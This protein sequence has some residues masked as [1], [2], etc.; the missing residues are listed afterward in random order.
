MPLRASRI[1]YMYLKLKSSHQFKSSNP[2]SDLDIHHVLKNN[3][4][5]SEQRGQDCILSKPVEW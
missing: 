2:S 3:L 1:H 4:D 5:A